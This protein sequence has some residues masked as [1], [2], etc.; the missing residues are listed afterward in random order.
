MSKDLAKDRVSIEQSGAKDSTLGG[1]IKILGDRGK[2][3]ENG[4]LPVTPRE[5]AGL[6]LKEKDQRYR[7]ALPLSFYF[8]YYID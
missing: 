8:T 2:E 3:Y 6:L 5:L 7:F 4:R 1:I